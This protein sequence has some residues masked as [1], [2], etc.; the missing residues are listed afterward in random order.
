[1]DEFLE[2][3]IEVE[4]IKQEEIK[5]ATKRRN[6]MEEKKLAFVPYCFRTACL[7]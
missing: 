1:L 5:K 6:N 7:S 4:K 3:D 2:D